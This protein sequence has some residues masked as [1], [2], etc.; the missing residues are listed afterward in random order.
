MRG[1]ASTEPDDVAPRRVAPLL[2]VTLVV[3]AALSAAVSD[4][5]F[6]L[7]E[8]AALRALN[9]APVAVGWPLRVAMQLG[10]VWAGIALAGVV[11]VLRRGRSWQAPA[12]VLLATA[13][14]HRADNVLK[15]VIDRQRPP[16]LVDGLD[17]RESIHGFGFPSG[18][19][20]MAFALA[21]VLHHLLP[22]RARWVPWALALAVGLARVHVGVHWP[23]DVAGGAALG[24]AIGSGAALL[25]A[26]WARSAGRSRT[27]A[28]PATVTRGEP[29]AGP[30]T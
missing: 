19:T 5:R 11:A 1:G 21:A 12:A 30:H 27:R 18:H 20:T 9:D 4:Q 15:D 2:V 6:L 25:A 26:W 28:A 22:A 29:R 7:G 3:L 10:T 14:A 8:T 13:A 16:G 17:V 24:T 23:A